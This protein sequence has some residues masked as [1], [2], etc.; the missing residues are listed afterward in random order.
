MAKSKTKAELEKELKEALSALEGYEGE[1]AGGELDLSWLP[2]KSQKQVKY[3]VERVCAKRQCEPS[4]VI[5]AC[6]A[7]CALQSTQRHGVHRLVQNIELSVK[8]KI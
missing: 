1:A 7:W 2:E 3:F 4:R 8:C 5:A 6:L